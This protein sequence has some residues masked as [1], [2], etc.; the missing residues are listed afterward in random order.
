MQLIV[1]DMYIASGSAPIIILNQ[2][3]IGG[4]TK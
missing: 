4:M 3:A 2:F 1:K